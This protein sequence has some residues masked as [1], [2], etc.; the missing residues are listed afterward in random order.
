M[1]NK[2]TLTERLNKV[3]DELEKNANVPATPPG[4]T[5]TG[6]LER[7]EKAAQHCGQFQGSIPMRKNK[8]GPE[9]TEKTA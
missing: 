4:K 6:A 2:P 8:H 1:P 3:A 9:K 5:A 7:V